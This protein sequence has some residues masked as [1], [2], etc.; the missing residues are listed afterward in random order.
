MEYNPNLYNEGVFATQGYNPNQAISGDFSSAYQTP[1]FAPQATGGAPAPEAPGGPGMDYMGMA[2]TAAQVGG[3][4]L[5]AYG[6]YQDR[7]EAKARYNDA[8]DEYKRQQRVEEKDRLREGQ[9]Q[10]RQENYFGADYSQNL[11][12]RFAGSYGGYRQPGGR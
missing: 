2:G 7:E 11:E 12:D 5:D 3:M 10:Q 6:K 9:R 1:S 4:A 8:M